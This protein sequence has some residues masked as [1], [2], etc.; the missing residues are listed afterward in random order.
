MV[1]ISLDPARD[2]TEKLQELATLHGIADAR[3]R[4]LRAPEDDVRELAAVLG[5]RYRSLPD[6]EL[7]HSPLLAL[8]DREGVIVTRSEPTAAEL[9]TLIAA[10]T[11]VARTRD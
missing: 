6:G 5:V 7:S 2:G 1:L 3:W 8:L 4:F 10:T 9:D 11:R